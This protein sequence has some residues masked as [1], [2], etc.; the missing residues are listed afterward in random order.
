MAAAGATPSNVAFFLN[1]LA[2]YAKNTTRISPVS[3]SQ[4]NA[5]ETIILRLPTNAIVDLKTLNVSFDARITA[6]NMGDGS[7]AAYYPRFSQSL[8]RRLDV[9]IGG[10]QVGLGSLG[11]YGAAWNLIA[12]NTIPYSKLEELG[13]LESVSLSNSAM[14]GQN[15]APQTVPATAIGAN[16]NGTTFTKPDVLPYKPAAVVGP[17]QV[18][19]TNVTPWVRKQMTQFMGLLEGKFNRFLDTNLLPDV[20]IRLTLANGAVLAQNTSV[21]STFS[22]T[23]NITTPTQPTVTPATALSFQVQNMFLQMETIAFGDNSYRS[24]VESRLGAGGSLTIPYTNLSL[25]ESATTSSSTTTQFTLATQS[26][27]TMLCTLRPGNY[28][29]FDRQIQNAS[30][31]STGTLVASLT[32]QA[33]QTP[34]YQFCSGDK[35]QSNTS[36]SG[37]VADSRRPDNGRYGATPAPFGTPTVFN[38]SYPSDGKYQA[39]VDG[40]PYPQ[41][42]PHLL[43]PFAFCFSPELLFDTALASYSSCRTAPTATTS[44]RRPSMGLVATPGTPTPS[45]TLPIGRRTPLPWASH[46]SITARMPSPSVL[47]VA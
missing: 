36:Y 26:L 34:Y 5:S 30:T 41:V 23:T 47:S 12:S 46:S 20:E 35:K 21:N 6:A 22:T 14:I 44:P 33:F 16:S 7:A 45:P 28:D 1:R 25:F 37:A 40:I 9:T 43:L 19:S 32:S 18:F 17:H 39:V 24:M 13:V 15:I 10:V 4:Y 2:G 3:K 42:S 27:D 29:S 38:Q 31:G 8:I 11:D